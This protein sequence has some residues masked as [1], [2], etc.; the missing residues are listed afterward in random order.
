VPSTPAM[1]L[2]QEESGPGGSAPKNPSVAEK[3]RPRAVPSVPQEAKPPGS[4][5][6]KRGIFVPKPVPSTTS[7]KRW[8]VVIGIQYTKEERAAWKD[9]GDIGSLKNAENDA[10]DVAQVLKEKY[11][12]PD[13]SIFLLRGKEATRD[14]IT[15]L[16]TEGL[17]CDATKV[18]PDD[19][20]LFYFSGHG[21]GP[22]PG[23]KSDEEHA[24]ILPCDAQVNEHGR[25]NTTFAIDIGAIAAKLRKVSE[26]N[27][28][29][30]LLILDCCH[31]GAVFQ[32]QG[33]LGGAFEHVGVD[34]SLLS[35]R[36]VQAIAASRATQLASDGTGRNSPFTASMLRALQEVPPSLPRERFFF[37]TNQL[38]Y[39]MKAYVGSSTSI[40]QSPQCRW[41]DG[42][43]AGEF[44]FF[45][46]PNARFDEI[47]DESRRLLLTM[48]PSTFGNWWAEEMPW[49][50]P[51]FR[52]EILEHRSE[53]KST[54]ADEVDKSKLREAAILTLK[55]L[56]SDKNVTGMRRLRLDHLQV[57]L[58]AEESADRK[59]Q[60]RKVIKQLKEAVDKPSND[61]PE[62]EAVDVHY[63]AVLEHVVGEQIAARANYE[64]ALKLY[65]QESKR[66]VRMQALEALCRSD[67]GMLLSELNE[68]D[69]SFEEFR[70]ARSLFG[71]GAPIPFRVF[72]LTQE[73]NTQL[74][75]GF[76]GA[77]DV[78]M[79][80]AV[81]LAKKFDPD[82]THPLTASV[83]NNYAWAKM[84]QW[85]FGEA[86]LKFKKTQEILSKK[87]NLDRPECQVDQLHAKHGLAMIHRFMGADEEATKAY[88]SLTREIS[89]EIR[90]LE[91]NSSRELNLAEVRALLYDR[92]VNSLERQADC[93]LFGRRPDFEAAAFYYRRGLQ[94]VGQVPGNRRAAIERD[95]LYRQ[96]IALF[97][98]SFEAVASNEKDEVPS[99]QVDVQT[100]G[101]R[102]SDAPLVGSTRA[103]LR[104]QAR[105]ILKRA[106]STD[107]ASE[108]PPIN[109]V[110]D[111]GI[112]ASLSLA[113]EADASHPADVAQKGGGR[114]G[115]PTGAPEKEE[116]R[117]A[118]SNVTPQ[119]DLA[120]LLDQLRGKKRDFDRDELERL[121]F[122]YRLLIEQGEGKLDR[123]KRLELAERLHEH[124]QSALRLANADPGVLTYLRP[125]YDA[126]FR[127]KVKYQPVGTKELIELIWEATTGELNP[128]PVANQPV[129]ALYFLDDRCHLVLDAPHGRSG[130]FEIDPE[131]VRSVEIIKQA[132]ES[133]RSL[134]CPDGLRKRLRAIRLA[135]GQKLL[136]HYRDPVRG[137]GEPRLPFGQLT[138]VTLKP[139]A[140]KAL[141]PVPASLVFPFDVR[142]A[143]AD[144]SY[145]VGKIEVVGPLKQDNPS[146]EISAPPITETSRV[147]SNH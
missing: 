94:M 119:V 100:Q 90:G 115:K 112:A 44:T 67:Y 110:L 56:K 41:L 103:F 116:S 72:C 95:L 142:S 107:L 28:R 105:R 101:Q 125:Y 97:L 34:D 47:S 25:P 57:I 129:L 46:D 130:R 6:A 117:T 68:N 62:P 37:T 111:E 21:V 131:E 92:L 123:F 8:A 54:L 14:A 128:P 71:L 93:Y 29:H 12:Y 102:S 52:L 108:V 146:E 42:T 61:G 78:C 88:A 121:M 20:V 91:R 84:R 22:E 23:A 140:D 49:F 53:T 118:P 3:S 124:C 30:V 4:T 80:K 98:Q 64:Q 141:N 82:E 59:H 74:A 51:G 2:V 104:E 144:P 139:P 13:S 114:T 10:A 143:L 66:F 69:K 26:C 48:V 106:S 27:A 79:D 70:T 113:A 19:S 83:Y 126:V 145:E 24:Y 35:T 87:A 75:K 147:S 38:F 109:V 16:L 18:G 132:G 39:A 9:R 40:E 60:Y 137:I 76:S 77:S 134:P 122:A 89:D 133:G 43:N 15:N 45:P 81:S 33:T 63:L 65:A 96:A 31:S 136:V 50:M 5:E 36:S 7:G 135:K 138:R 55:R 73:A 58:D 17:F 1:A 32:M 120:V 86:K 85:Q 11:G 127:V 99:V